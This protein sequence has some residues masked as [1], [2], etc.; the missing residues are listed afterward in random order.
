MTTEMILVYVGLMGISAI[1]GWHMG[2]NRGT[3][4]TISKLVANKYVAYRQDKITGEV[5]LIEHPEAKDG[6]Q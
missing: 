4:V 5:S 6:G 1:A 2:R 3:T